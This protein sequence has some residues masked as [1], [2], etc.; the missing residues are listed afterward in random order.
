MDVEPYS[1]MEEP[2]IDPANFFLVKIDGRRVLVDAGPS[3]SPP[4]GFPASLSL[5]AVLLTHWHWDHVRGVTWAARSARYVCASEETLRSIDPGRAAERMALMVKAVFGEFEDSLTAMELVVEAMTS[6]YE[7]S[8]RALSRARVYTLAECPLI[9]EGLVEYVECPGHSHDHI[10]YIVG[11]YVFVGD[12]IVPGSS[13]TLV[14]Y[15]KYLD[16]MIKLLGMK[17]EVAAVGHRG[18]FLGKAEASK[19]IAEVVRGKMERLVL[20]AALAGKDWVS[21]LDVFK[22]VYGGNLSPKG[23]VAARSLVGYVSLLEELG[24]IE[25]DRTRAPWRIKARV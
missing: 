18:P 19:Y 23:F 25:V 3:T 10:C 7:D 2:L 4:E 22:R 12:N 21:L 20:I 17:W 1:S 24:V 9:R 14:D 15:Q 13:V 11:G 8:V 6:F 5:E 16:S